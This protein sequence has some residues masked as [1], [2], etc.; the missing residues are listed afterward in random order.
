MTAVMEH[1]AARTLIDETLFSRLAT[2]IT[3]DHGMDHD[4]AER[5]MDQALAFLAA[6]A[7]NRCAPIS[8]SPMVDIGWHTFILYTREYAE[9]CQRI[10][11]RFIHHVPD[12]ESDT[13]DRVS[14]HD[15]GRS[16]TLV[17]IEHAGYAIDPELWPLTDGSCGPCHEEGNCAAS[18]KDGNENTDK[19]TK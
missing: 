8:P 12:D 5:I 11:G 7:T 1:T 13:A 3:I 17:A 18:G 15:E 9:F 16:P 2:R 10:A 4:M 6:A 19:R 14:A